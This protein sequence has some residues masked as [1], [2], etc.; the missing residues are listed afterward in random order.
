MSELFEFIT[1]SENTNLQ[2]KQKL[3]ESESADIAEL[4]DELDH[5][6]TARVF[7]LLSKDAAATVFAY[8]ER[9]HQEH[10]LEVLTDKEIAGVVNDMFFDDTVDLLEEMPANLVKRI[11]SNAS[12]TTR[13]EV[14]KLLQ[15]PEFSAGSIMTTELV[16]LR[17]EMTVREAFTKIRLTG[18]DKETIY[19]CYI[20]APD[21]T[22]LGT[23]SVKELLFAGPEDKLANLMEENYICVTTSDDREKVAAEFHKYGLLSVPVVDS[24][25]RLVGIITADDIIDVIQAE[26]TED[27]A[28]MN[29]VLPSEKEYLQESTFKHFTRRI[30]WLAIL[31]VSGIVAG[32]ILQGFENVLNKVMLLTMYMPFL[33]GTGGNAG[34]QSSTLIIRG[35]AVNEIKPRDIWR[36]IFKEARIALFAALMLAP[37]VLLKVRFLDLNNATYLLDGVQT[38]YD[39]AQI[40]FMALTVILSLTA[41]LVVAKVIGGVLPVLA[42]LCKLDPAVMAAPLLTPGVDACTLV[43]YFGLASA[44]VLPLFSGVS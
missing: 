30:V 40:Y 43:I 14:N 22:L 20:M 39:S 6:S 9:D 11:I 31:A 13:T 12:E 44:M 16:S 41:A 29:A 15:Y 3:A 18:T 17:K 21:R 10:L 24:E 4:F 38:P 28:K 23:V 35:L 42:K 26:D 36:I 27:I 5:R 1:N 33:M 34:S 32:F 37:I 25:R 7:R 8:L 2:I 19:T